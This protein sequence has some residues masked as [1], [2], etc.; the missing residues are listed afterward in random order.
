MH[1][2]ILTPWYYPL[3]HPRPH[4]WTALAEHWAAQGHKVQVL[5]GR[6]VG[7]AQSEVCNGVQVERVGFDSL[8]TAFFH[9]I[10]KKG[11]RG[12]VGSAIG[13]PN[14]LFRL[15][16]WAYKTLWRGLCF[17]DDACLWYWP[18]RRALFRH[19]SQ[20]PP[21]VLITVSLPFTAHLLG[22]AAKRRYPA[23]RWVADI[24]DPF[25]MPEFPLNNTWLY[26]N[27]NRR[28]EK[29]VLETA[30]DVAVTTAALVQ[31]YAKAFGKNAVRRMAVIGPLS[32]W[33]VPPTPP[34]A[35]GRRLRIGYFGAMYAPVR[36]PDAFLDLCDQIQR[37]RPSWF[38]AVELHFYGE[39]FPE[40]LPRLQ[41]CP[42][43]VLHG[44][45][46]RAEAR[47]AMMD[48]DVLLN[49]GNQTAF[50]LPSK[51][52]DYLAAGKPVLN[53]SYVADDPF[54]E[55]FGAWEGLL[56][57]PVRNGKLEPDGAL[58]CL[59]WLDALPPM[60]I[61]G[62]LEAVLRDFLLPSVADRYVSLFR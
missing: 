20:G 15:A 12:H 10:D 25:S 33:S 53:L 41:R 29:K 50:Q 42:A 36:T 52:V 17:P 8:K 27:I 32:T 43:V 28:L 47:A 62:A 7:C 19:L 56:N 48:M 55:M 5:T 30:D 23:L 51:T 24:G 16:I 40:F 57:L 13:M 1:L 38:D 58:R 54:R 39:V 2:L 46:P 44:L 9:A 26:A 35:P 21:D 45:R 60:R 59:A 31:T 37:L 3:I 34:I 61:G 14:W 6:Q 4:R 18:A 11:G 49:L 22:L